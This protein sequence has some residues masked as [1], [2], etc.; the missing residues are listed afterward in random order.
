MSGF[1]DVAGKGR[2]VT[3]LSG[4]IDL[5]ATLSD[6]R[7]VRVRVIR[8]RQ[9]PSP[10]FRVQQE[11]M[12]LLCTWVGEGTEW[13]RQEDVVRMP[14]ERAATPAHRAAMRDGAQVQR[15]A[16]FAVAVFKGECWAESAAGGCVYPSVARLRAF[17]SLISG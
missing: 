13:L 1:H 16:P 5:F 11:G 6:A 7:T 9:R 17:A 12:R 8:T 3:E 10:H 2:L 15:L 4:L 14:L